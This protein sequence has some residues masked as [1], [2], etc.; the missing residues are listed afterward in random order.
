M[1]QKCLRHPEKEAIGRC[2]YCGRHLCAACVVFNSR[3][4]LFSCTRE[5]DCMAYQEAQ[6]NPIEIRLMEA[7]LKKYHRRLSEVLEE[8]G[9]A[10]KVFQETSAR[11]N[12]GAPESEL[13]SRITNDVNKIVRIAGYCAYKLAE[14]GMALLSLIAIKSSLLKSI[15]EQSGSSVSFHVQDYINKINDLE[16]MIRQTLD[17]MAPFSTLESRKIIESVCQRAATRRERKSYEEG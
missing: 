10:G 7:A 15:C 1:S 2:R 9:E 14:E 11:I 8:L 13:V 16:P 17:D 6:P 5:S 12:L 4:K 3:D